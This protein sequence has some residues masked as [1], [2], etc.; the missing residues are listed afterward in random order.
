MGHSPKVPVTQETNEHETEVT[1]GTCKNTGW[2]P[3]EA[4]PS[5]ALACGKP[6]L[7]SAP[8]RQNRAGPVRTGHPRLGH[9]WGYQ[10]GRG[11]QGSLVASQQLTTVN[12]D[13]PPPI[14]SLFVV[15]VALLWALSPVTLYLIMNQG[16]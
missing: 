5:A 4:E 11:Q 2:T 12:A 13:W 10:G 8:Q 7:P 14:L 15:L 16:S 1:E 6:G 9:S 3:T